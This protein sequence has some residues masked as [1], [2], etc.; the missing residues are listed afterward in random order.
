M[1]E[2]GRSEG[3]NKGTDT[4]HDCPQRLNRAPKER[5]AASLIA[6][7]MD[8][9]LFVSHCIEKLREILHQARLE[10]VVFLSVCTFLLVRNGLQ[11][12]FRYGMTTINFKVIAFVA[13]VSLLLGPW[14]VESQGACFHLSPLETGKPHPAGSCQAEGD[15][16]L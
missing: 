8:S 5:T 1:F 13:L 4:T 10:I 2:T 16:A 3:H 15:S 7:I 12:A 14:M 6:T 9:S 11:V